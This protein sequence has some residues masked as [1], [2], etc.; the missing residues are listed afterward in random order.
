MELIIELMYLEVG[1]IG[2]MG[3]VG[4][5]MTV[6]PPSSGNTEILWTPRN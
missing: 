4:L 3:C 2:L 5:A 1:E 6:L